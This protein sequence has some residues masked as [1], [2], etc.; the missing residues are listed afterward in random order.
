M[1]SFN[2]K[3]LKYQLVESHFS[4]ELPNTTSQFQYEQ[5]MY[6]IEI[7]DFDTLSN[8]IING[9]KW[10]WLINIKL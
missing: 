9:L 3:G 2:Y 5:L 8:R 7:Q 4:D 10:G 6:C 1:K